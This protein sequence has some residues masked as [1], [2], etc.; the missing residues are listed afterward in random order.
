MFTKA[1]EKQAFREISKALECAQG[2]SAKTTG[3]AIKTGAITGTEAPTGTIACHGSFDRR[4]RSSRE[5]Q[6]PPLKAA[7]A[8][9]YEA[10]A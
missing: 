10:R 8:R 4:A 3:T 7:R 9:A 2:V 5:I 1:C 6:S